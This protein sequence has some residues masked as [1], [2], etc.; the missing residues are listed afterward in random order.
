MN[1][2]FPI[3]RN[4]H[5]LKIS[6]FPADIYNIEF[7]F[8]H[9]THHGNHHRRHQKYQSNQNW[10][11]QHMSPGR[12]PPVARRFMVKPR[13]MGENVCVAWRLMNCCQAVFGK[14]RNVDNQREKHIPQFLY[15]SDHTFTRQLNKTSNKNSPNLVFP[16]LKALPIQKFSLHQVP[17]QPL[18]N[19]APKTHSSLTTLRIRAWFLGI[20]SALPKPFLILPFYL[21]NGALKL[22]Q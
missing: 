15:D 5:T 22:G 14:P 10:A 8:M 7:M 17:P 4:I 3:S 21:L 16:S 19:L 20:I 6:I 11:T 13:K 12:S 9:I 2:K 18:L 1:P